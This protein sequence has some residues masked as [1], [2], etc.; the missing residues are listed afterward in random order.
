MPEPSV[1]RVLPIALTLLLAACSS[2][3]RRRSRA[4]VRPE[5]ES[6]APSEAE[7]DVV[8]VAM[9]DSIPFNLEEDC[10]G[11]T[12]FVDSYSRALEAELGEPVAV[13]NRSRHDGARTS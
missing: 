4:A 3:D 7:P 12:G 11:C 2:G 9:G 5:T 13:V 6:Q 10:P 1:P 8:L